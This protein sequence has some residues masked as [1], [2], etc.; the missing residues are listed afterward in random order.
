[1]ASKKLSPVGVAVMIVVMMA[2]II[3]LRPPF[4]DRIDSGLLRILASAGFG[5][6][7]ALIGGAVAMAFGLT[8]P[9]DE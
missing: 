3:V 5:A 1:M 6:A 7:G 8:Q 2:V 9:V 4:V